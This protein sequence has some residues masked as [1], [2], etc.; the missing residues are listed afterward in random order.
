MTA[1]LRRA[2]LAT[3]IWFALN[4]FGV[5]SF[6]VRLPEVK[7][8]LDIS[9]STL[10][11][12]LFIASLGSLACIKL[13]GKI[14]A[15]FGSS[16]VMI[17]GG[18]MTAISLP[19]ISILSS[20]PV[21]IFTLLI[22]FISITIMDIS[23]NAHAVNIEHQSDKLI[24]GRLHGIWSIGG[25]IGGIA[26]GIFESLNTRLF[27]QGFFVGIITLSL[28]AIFKRYLLPASADIH[29]PEESETKSTKHPKIF[30]ILGFVGLCAAVIEGSAAD[31]GAVL[32]TEEF[33]ATGFVSSL[34]YIIFQSAM[35]IGRFSSDFLT[36]KFGRGPIL[37]FCGSFVAIG[38]S[39]G[40]F[41]GGQ[42]AIVLSWF[43]MGVGASVVIPMVFSIA[44]AI[45]KNEYAGQVAPSQA[46]ATVSGISYAA[47]L[48][49]PPIIG[50]IADAISLRWAMLVPAILA[51][52]II[53][54][55][56]FANKA[57]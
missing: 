56:K 28:V 29:A 35:V 11:L 7:Q 15:K 38:L 8:T 44:G 20:L 57:N 18:I 39:T 53:F 50:F 26:G 10:G 3:A 45:A 47:F 25:V 42:I 2:W 17:L 32:I 37:L 41:V 30:Y 36:S 5:A 23:M 54:G 40:L 21:F 14:A 4:S 27:H 12:A 52:G 6:I 34:P 48:V 13:V 43:A 1:E 16:P 49:G 24:M 9:N 31:W 19:L 46:V 22:F 51:L 33:G 55:A